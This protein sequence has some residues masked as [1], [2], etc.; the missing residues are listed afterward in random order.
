MST[1]AKTNRG[2]VA[3]PE[4]RAALIAAAREIFGSDGVDAPLS[5]IAK[6]AGVGQGSLYRHFPDRASLILAVFD[7]N[8]REIEQAAAQPETTLRSLADLVT[9]QT[10]GVAPLIGVTDGDERLRELEDRLRAAFTPKWNEAQRLGTVG[11]HATM[12]DLMMAIAMVA[13]VVT[14]AAE[15][16]R[17]AVATAAW[18]LLRPGLNRST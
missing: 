10:E 12:N 14:H 2:P 9:H 1:R 3:G 18:E 17:H 6:R 15:P 16:E 7:E 8:M 11:T 5:S 13:T 4:N